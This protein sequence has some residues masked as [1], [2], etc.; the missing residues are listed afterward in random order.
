MEGIDLNLVLSGTSD[1]P[2]CPSGRIPNK[3]QDKGFRTLF[4]KKSSE[5]LSKQSLRIPPPTFSKLL[6]MT[7]Q[8]YTDC[9]INTI[10][11]KLS[12]EDFVTIADDCSLQK[13]YAT[14]HKING[15]L[16][17]F[18]SASKKCSKSLYDNFKCPES[19]I[20]EN[21]PD[22]IRECYWVPC[23]KCRPPHFKCLKCRGSGVLDAY[24]EPK[25]KTIRSIIRT[26]I[27]N[28]MPKLCCAMSEEN[29]SI[30]HEN[31]SCNNCGV[32]P[33]IGHRYKCSVCNNFDF[34]QVCEKTTLHDHPFIKIRN[35]EMA[36][37]VI[38]CAVD[39]SKKKT[40][41]PKNRQCEP[42][43]RL[44]CRFVKDVVG[45]EGDI[46]PPG[47]CFMKT[48]K[49]RNDGLTEW[50]L[51]CKL[52]FTNGDF[53]GNEVLLPCLM[54][55]EEKDV[56]VICKCPD[57]DGRYNSYWR[58]V[59]PTGNRFGQR[60]TIVINVQ[61]AEEKKEDELKTLVEIFNNPELVKLAY[62]KAGK[63]AQKAAE[64]LFSGNLY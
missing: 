47:D 15:S 13:A 38:I 64:I 54:P 40:C 45:N 1:I 12:D 62:E 23:Y 41:K 50:P 35:P 16:Q 24:E 26:E 51:G 32:F 5:L 39:E 43:T 20:L 44:L 58:A 17:L 34:C 37:K 18:I 33:I 7:Q 14:G 53:G 6:Q 57:K 48:W 2:K 52:V 11:Y 21:P 25:L 60:L 46:H 30:V 55:N 4:S 36:P 28:Y 63:C 3:F 29:S 27:K 59:D 8:V 49:L 10:A 22:I 42:A 9:F 31:I 19:I 56:S 61:R